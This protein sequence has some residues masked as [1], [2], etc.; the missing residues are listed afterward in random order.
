[1]VAALLWFCC[2]WLLRVLCLLAGLLVFVFTF[3]LWFCCRA[4][5]CLECFGCLDLV[6][7]QLFVL[8]WLVV[9]LVGCVD[10]V[11]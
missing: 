6:G 5:G 4:V 3:G 1:M 2:R 9:S 7:G 10:S 11:G 8:G